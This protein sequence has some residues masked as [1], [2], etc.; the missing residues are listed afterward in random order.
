[1]SISIRQLKAFVAIASTGSFIEASARLR[2]SQPALSISIRKLELHIGGAVFIRSPRGAQLTP[3]GL[4]FL[5]KAQRLVL[6]WDDA[7][8]DLEMLF[9]KQQG[10]ITIAALPTLA[11]GFLPKVLAEYRAQFPNIAINVNDVLASEIEGLVREGRADFG[12]SVQPAKNGYFDFEPLFEDRF[13]AVCPESHPLMEC[14]EVSWAQLLKYPIIELNQLSST[15]QA[16]EQ[17]LNDINLEMDLFCEVRQIGTA[18]RMVAAGLGVAALPS[19]SFR[20]ISNEGLGWRTLIEPAVPRQLGIIKPPRAALPVA[21][22]AM[23]EIIRYHATQ[24]EELKNLGV[25]G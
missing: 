3:E 4:S 10:K 25:K 12:L 8:E 18:G 23:L 7:F 9:K 17:V 19:L 16:I 6:D 11:A 20:Q 15:R 5:P 14:T 24:F 21:S 2:L 22:N 1:M 13:V